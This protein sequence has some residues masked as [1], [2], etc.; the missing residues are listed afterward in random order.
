MRK[1]MPYAL[2]RCTGYDYNIRCLEVATRG[3]MC[4]RHY[5]REWLRAKRGTQIYRL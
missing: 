5:Q 3:T 2:V 1:D 4:K